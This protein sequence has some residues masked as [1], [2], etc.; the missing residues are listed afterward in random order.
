MDG[1][2][3]ISAELNDVTPSGRLRLQTTQGEIREYGFKE[4]IYLL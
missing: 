3:V 2:G 4:V 1:T